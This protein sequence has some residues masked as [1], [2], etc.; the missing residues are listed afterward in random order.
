MARLP[1]L[2]TITYG[3]AACSSTAASSP[4]RSPRPKPPTSISSWPKRRPTPVRPAVKKSCAS[5]SPGRRSPQR[6]SSLDRREALP[7]GAE[8]VRRVRDRADRHAQ[9]V[10]VPPGVRFHGDQQPLVLV[11]QSRPQGGPGGIVD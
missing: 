4:R 7:D 10:F 2:L 8:V 6:G 3:I 1:R 5:T 9:R 11:A